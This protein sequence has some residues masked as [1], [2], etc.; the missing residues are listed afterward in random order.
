MRLRF[1]GGC[2]TINF[3]KFIQDGGDVVKYTRQY[4]VD[5]DTTLVF[6]NG[7]DIY[8][9]G[10]KR[11]VNL[12][13]KQALKHIIRNDKAILLI[14]YERDSFNPLEIDFENEWENKYEN[15]ISFDDEIYL[16]DYKN[17]YAYIVEVYEKAPS[18]LMVIF[19]YH[20]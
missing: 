5:N 20:H 4:D 2:G 1:L 3:R 18:D 13:N 6:C 12:E 19:Y 16:G 7:E 10:Y 15:N 9:I 11:V 8:N 14:N 17:G